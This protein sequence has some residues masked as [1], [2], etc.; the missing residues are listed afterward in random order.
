PSTL[1]CTERSDFGSVMTATSVRFVPAKSPAAM[2]LA[3]TVVTLRTLIGTIAFGVGETTAL[4]SGVAVAGA[5]LGGGRAVV[6][7]T[8][9]AE[10]SASAR[11]PITA[12][13]KRIRRAIRRV[14]FGR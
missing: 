9:N 10:R 5:E 2:T 11:P 8:S 7:D 3:P 6:H 14:A 12:P 4:A 13:G 1:I